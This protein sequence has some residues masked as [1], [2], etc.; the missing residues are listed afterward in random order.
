MAVGHVFCDYFALLCQF[1][2]YRYSVVIRLA[3]GEGRCYAQVYGLVLKREYRKLVN[4]GPDMPTSLL[5]K[6]LLSG[7]FLP[8]ELSSHNLRYDLYAQLCAANNVTASS[9]SSQPSLIIFFSE[10]ESSELV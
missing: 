3:A 2:F 1:P 7:I 9:A 10:E 8:L 5:M 6:H 4:S